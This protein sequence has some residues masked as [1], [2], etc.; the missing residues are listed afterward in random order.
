MVF[1]L[2]I[3]R[4]DDRPVDPATVLVRVLV[5]Y[6]SLFMAGLGFLWCLWDPE[7]QTWHDKVAGTI[8]VRAPKGMSLV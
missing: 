6:V 2:K 1:S 7:Q 3:V 4:L 5:G 8:V